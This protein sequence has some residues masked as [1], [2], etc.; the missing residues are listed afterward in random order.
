MNETSEEAAGPATWPPALTLR[1]EQPV[2]GMRIALPRGFSLDWVADTDDGE[3][4][5]EVA[6]EEVE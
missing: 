6:A 2:N 1:I 4:I 5:W 3:T